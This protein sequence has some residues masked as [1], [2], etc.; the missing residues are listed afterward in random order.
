MQR[1]KQ[2]N[3][4]ILKDIEETILLRFYI[5][6]TYQYHDVPHVSLYYLKKANKR[7]LSCDA[8]VV[9]RAVYHKVPHIY[10][11]A[12]HSLWDHEPQLPCIYT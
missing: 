4:A 2:E 10:R 3:G 5:C 8:I 11:M 7:M 12:Q 9:S 6:V 1:Q